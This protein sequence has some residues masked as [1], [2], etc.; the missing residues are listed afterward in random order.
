MA[1]LQA[2]WTDATVAAWTD[3]VVCIH[4]IVMWFAAL[5]GIEWTSRATWFGAKVSTGQS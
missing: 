2:M 3:I 4:V 1:T 5:M